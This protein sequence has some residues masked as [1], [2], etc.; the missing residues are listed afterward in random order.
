MFYEL[1]ALDPF[2]ASPWKR[3]NDGVPNGTFQGSLELLARLSVELDTNPEFSQKQYFN[4]TPT[5]TGNVAVPESGDLDL[6]DLLPD[7]I[8]NLLPDG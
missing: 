8:P 4:D 6:I 2:G 7:E 5:I 3:S 1:N